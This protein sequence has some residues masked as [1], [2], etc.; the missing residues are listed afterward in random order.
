MLPC[1]KNA[2]YGALHW[3]FREAACDARLL[4]TYLEN[5]ARP[6]DPR[7]SIKVSNAAFAQRVA[8][9]RGARALLYALGFRTC[10][11]DCVRVDAVADA[12]LFNDVAALLRRGETSDAPSPPWTRCEPN[13]AGGGSWGGGD[14]GRFRNSDRFWRTGDGGQGRGPGPPPPPPGGAPSSGGAWGR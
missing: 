10:G 4:A 11:I 5:A 12:R 13:D 9:S 1:S 8:P 6:V 2:A 14:R 3:L 7:R